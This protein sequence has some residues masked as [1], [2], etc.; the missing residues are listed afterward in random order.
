MISNGKLYLIIGTGKAWAWH[1]KAKLELILR[2]NMLTLESVENV[3]AFAPTGSKRV[4][5]KIISDF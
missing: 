2:T 5:K 3:G 1:S 4:K